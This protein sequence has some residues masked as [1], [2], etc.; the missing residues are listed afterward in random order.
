MDERAVMVVGATGFAGKSLVTQLSN[1]GHRVFA[2]SRN[3]YRLP[4]LA[5]VEA[6]AQPMDNSTL[7]HQLLPHCKI[8]IHLASDS[9]PGSTST[10]PAL[11]AGANLLPTLRMLE[12][13]QSYPQIPL[14]YTSSG[15]ATYVSTDSARSE[16]SSLAPLSYYGAGKVA[17]ERFLHAYTHQFRGR[18]VVLRPSNLYGP[19]QAFK[20]G[21]GIV[22]TAF[23]HLLAGSPMEIW[24]D[25]KIVRDYL[26]VDDFTRLCAALIEREFAPGSFAVYNAGSGVGASINAICALAE[27]VSGMKLTR[28]FRHGRAVDSPSI[29]LDC[30]K[31]RRELGWNASVS[32]ESG[33]KYT[34]DWH[35]QHAT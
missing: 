25:G 13:M 30:E 33:M 7:L 5:N 31:A 15:G 17:I 21:F 35:R 10:Q 6:F 11:E 23:H 14:I 20:R 9:T 34:W 2:L 29:V 1:S 19:G 4:A 26:Y 12:V 16:T 22:P 18:V 32:I 28:Q 24:G 3:A 27:E 8:V